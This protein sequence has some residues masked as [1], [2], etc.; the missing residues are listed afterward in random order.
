MRKLADMISLRRD[1]DAVL[2]MARRY[3]AEAARLECRL[4][5]L[6]QMV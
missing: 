3:D 5:A 6:H 4:I 1:R 2:D